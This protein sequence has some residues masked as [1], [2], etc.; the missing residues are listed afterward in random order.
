MSTVHTSMKA[1]VV[2]C[3]YP[4]GGLWVR[5]TS[6]PKR[7]KTDIRSK[8]IDDEL[9]AVDNEVDAFKFV[10]VDNGVD[11][12]STASSSSSSTTRSSTRRRLFEST[13]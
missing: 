3:A 7:D 2:A 6:D 9:E 12:R 11:D 5:W 13:L 10:I 1:Y 4:G 8:V